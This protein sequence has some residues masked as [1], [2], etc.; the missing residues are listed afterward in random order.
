MET[1]RGHVAN[2]TKPIVLLESRGRPEDTSPW[3]EVALIHP[4]GRLR[5]QVADKREPLGPDWKSWRTRTGEHLDAFPGF[6]AFEA[7]DLGS[8]A[9]EHL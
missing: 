1:L 2:A 3:L 7:V 4:A 8:V 9:G 5:Y 6:D